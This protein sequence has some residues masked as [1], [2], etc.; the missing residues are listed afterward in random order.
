MRKMANETRRR[1]EQSHGIF[2]LLMGPGPH[3]HPLESHQSL[4]LLGVDLNPANSFL[5]AGWC[6]VAA[7]CSVSNRL[8]LSS[9]LNNG[10]CETGFLWLP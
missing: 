6:I 5:I 2:T 10:Q 1:M 9:E 8:T 4:S 3:L 7:T